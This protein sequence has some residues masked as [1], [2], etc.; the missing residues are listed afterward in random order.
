MKRDPRHRIR[1]RVAAAVS[2]AAL[3]LSAAVGAQAAPA[4]TAARAAP[5]PAQLDQLIHAFVGAHPSFPGVTLSVT[6]PTLTWS[7]AAGFADRATRKPLTA[8]AGFRIAS[9]TKTFT[10]AAILRL[11]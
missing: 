10:A 6:T 9:V 5:L 4:P 8:S 7:G 11:A 3:L 1:P 2:L